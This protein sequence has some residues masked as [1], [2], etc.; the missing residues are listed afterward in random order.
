[1]ATSRPSTISFPVGGPLQRAELPALCERLHALLAAGAAD[2]V[3]C[4]LDAAVSADAVAVDALARLQL[5]AR[6]LG[7]RVRFRRVSPGLEDLLAFTGLVPVLLCRRALRETEER[8][9]PL[10]VEEERELGDTAA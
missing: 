1:M 7:C 9:D 6:R 5:T 8:E 3:V 10:G 4:D 2:V